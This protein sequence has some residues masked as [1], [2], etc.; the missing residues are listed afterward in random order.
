MNKIEKKNWVSK[1]NLLGTVH[2]SD[3]SFQIDKTS[4]SSSWQ[5][6]RMNLCVNCGNESGNIYVNMM[7]GFDNKKSSVIYAHGKTNDGRDDFENRIQ[8]D[9]DD[10]NNSDVLD[11][12]GDLCFVQIGL[13]RTESGKVLYEKFLSEYDAIEYLNR[14]LHESDQIYVS[15]NLKYSLYDGN[16]QI[17][18][19]VT[20]ITIYTPKENVEFVPYAKFTQSILINKD[21]ASFKNVDKDKGVMY[22]NAKVLDYIKELNGV[23]I[24]GQYPYPVE[25]EFKLNLANQKQCELIYKKLFSVKKGYTQITFEGVFIES[26]A[27][28]TAT[29]DD[30]T[31]DIKELIAMGLYTEEEVLSTVAT[32]GS[33]E[34]RMVLLKPFI[35]FLG[36]DENKVPMVS[37]F[38]ERYTEEDLIIDTGVS[39]NDFENAVP[40]G[41]DD[42]TDWLKLV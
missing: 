5:Y 37:K 41:S 30:V 38:E 32:N 2:L 11:N 34:K 36:D 21:S 13:K 3:G 7:G 25:F 22:V 33:R 4:T 29:M 28:T 10:R 35:T 26:G 8:V 6:N 15:G 40:I 9:W 19:N 20:R 42:D 39:A 18:K 14:N 16:V 23:E 12:I 31:D 27:T 1:F 24:R 17:Q